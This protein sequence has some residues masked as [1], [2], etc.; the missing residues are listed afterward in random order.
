MAAA[1][2][3]TNPKMTTAGR[4]ALRAAEARDSFGFLGLSGLIR[5]PK[6]RKLNKYVTG[7]AT[8]SKEEP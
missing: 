1:L 2:P 7:V 8:N 6:G 5:P 4:M 3:K